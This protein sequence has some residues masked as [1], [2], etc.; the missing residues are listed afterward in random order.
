METLAILADL[1]TAS[2]G[3]SVVCG[4]L[5]NELSRWFNVIYFGRFGQEREFASKIS[6]LPNEHFGYVPC[7]GG[8]WDRELVV[9]ILKHYKEIDYVFS[10]DDWFSA[11]GLLHGCNFWKK[12]F[13]FLTPIDSLPVPDEAFTNIFSRC[14]KLY[15]P[16]SSW[17]I[18]NGKKRLESTSG[19]TIKRAGKHLKSV[20]LPHGCSPVF[21]PKKVPRSDRFT[22]LWIGRIEQR[23]N[24][25]AFVLAAEKICDKMDADFFMRSDWKTPPAT[26]LLQYIKKKNLPFILDSMADIP[27]AEMVDVYNKGDIN[28]CTAKAGGFEMSV[29][30]A[31]GCGLPTLV[32]DWT[33]MNEN[34]VHGKSGLLIPTSGFCHPPPPDP[35]DPKTS[36]VAYNRIWG[37]ISVNTLAK[38][39]LWAY[40]NQEFVKAMGRWGRANIHKN[41]QWRTIAEKLKKE[42]L[43]ERDQAVVDG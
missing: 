35:R 43:Y 10:E 4:N 39:M 17:E 42:I 41:Y 21:K 25:G 31:A 3:F 7:Q 15:V 6:T 11:D 33:F 24:P 26:R 23:K 5:G 14:D 19:H 27:H 22:F 12:P 32:T 9:R 2:T 29:T 40:E 13:H 38:R 28:A 16:N 20:N 8:V 36:D 1:P 34:V 18:F 37:N 30:E